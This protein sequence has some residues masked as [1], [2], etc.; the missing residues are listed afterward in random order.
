M[1]TVDERLALRET[2][3]ENAVDGAIKS[4]LFGGVVAEL[5]R[6]HCRIERR[7]EMPSD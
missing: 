7:G 3:L 4:L 6:L 1:H 2:R 5:I